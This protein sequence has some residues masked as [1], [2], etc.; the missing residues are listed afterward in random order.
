MD[1]E[2]LHVL[3]FTLHDA[4]QIEGILRLARR[5]CPA[6]GG[7][8]ILLL[9]DLQDA[10]AAELP[11]DAPMLR[12]LQSGAMA[13]NARSGCGCFLLARARVWD[14]AQRAYLGAGKKTS[15]RETT[16]QLIK[17]G[18]ADSP[19]AAA[20]I[21]P[22]SLKDRFSCILFSDLSLSCTPDTPA[23]MAAVLERSAS[24]CVC[25]RVLEKR[26]FPQTALS[27]LH[28]G[29]PFSLSPLL[30]ARQD[31]LLI[32]GESLT[33]APAMYTAETLA[34]SLDQPV[35]SAPLAAD[36]FFVRIKPLTLPDDFRDHRLRCL[37]GSRMYALHPILQLF[38]LFLCA[39]AGLP[40]LAA[41]A[42]LPAEIWALVHPRH[43][44][45]ALLRLSLLPLTACVSLDAALCRLLAR[46]K[47]IRLRV[48]DALIAPQGC[49]L[50]G[51]ALLSIAMVTAQAL[52]F[53]LPVCLLWLAA[54][55]IAS[56]MDAPTLERIPL[57]TDRL[58]Q[59]RTLSE[60][61]FFDSLSARCS[62]SMRMLAACAGCM[63]GLLEPDEAAR[64]A[65]AQLA[66]LQDTPV[67][68]AALAAQLVS[69]QFLRERMGDCDAAL[70]ELPADIERH[71]LSLPLARSHGR[72][73]VL[74]AAAR[75]ECSEP[76][77]LK[78]LA[79]SEAP[80][81][82]ELLFLPMQSVRHTPVYPVSLP[83]TH[84]HTFL[85]KRLLAADT[86][87]RPTDAAMRF[88]FLCAATLGHPF[89]ALL[90]RSPV[91]GPYMP[92]LFI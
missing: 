3:C 37:H 70:R 65:Q 47:L 77:A 46:S 10:D 22:A 62:P 90:E 36:C 58:K 11:G 44:P 52:V 18:E 60:G 24:G 31:R 55:L 8:S 5:A 49:M 74:L 14:D 69:A 67:S 63:L 42:L 4:A 51:A 26:T 28:A 80:E 59:L 30:S 40:W 38:L 85:N 35:R 87:Q 15:F 81:P 50:F 7:H 48:P 75:Q 76:Q 41:L 2:L 68:A 78:H 89:H 43:L 66:S 17:N 25:A 73:S 1:G 92:L 88:L 83:L 33:D 32:K 61:A 56:A 16:A 71:A 23:R 45:A 84:P 12:T 19:F 9:C 72:L 39:L 34:A 29:I 20:T 64:Q 21:S 13:M 27:R 86:A 6:G 91:A 54:P 57:D 79:R 53:L 82:A